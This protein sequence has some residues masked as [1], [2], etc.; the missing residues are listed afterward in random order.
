MHVSKKGLAEIASHE[1]IVT[2]RY[3]D[4]VGVWTI[5][6]GHTANA[7][8]VNPTDIDRDLTIPEI[9]EIFSEDIQKFEKRVVAAFTRE[10]TQEQ[11]DAAVSFDFNTGGIHRATW[12]KKFNA[13][14]VSSAKKSFMAWSKPK[15]IIP[16]RK[17][18]RKLFFSGKYSGRGMANVYPAENGRVQ[19]KKGKRVDVL[20][21]VFQNETE[22][23]DNNK[24]SDKKTSN[25]P[26]IGGA[27]AAILL[28]VSAGW[29]KIEEFMQ[30]LF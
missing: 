18:E 1:G 9:M 28:A 14:D 17:K 3:K 5:G 21:N 6:I 27:G 26:L 24:V 2:S 4:S 23:K 22:V 16:R 10:L 13:G 7:G 11:F 8:G 19:W 12:V 30:W 20:N 29:S 15:E 25:A